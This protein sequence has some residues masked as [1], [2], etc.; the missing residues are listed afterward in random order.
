MESLKLL[1]EDFDKFL[2]QEQSQTDL[3]VKKFLMF[4]ANQAPT[5]QFIKELWDGDPHITELFNTALN[6][7]GRQGALSMFWFK[8]DTQKRA[9]LENWISHNYNG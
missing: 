9:E 4:G 8:L 3:G 6:E 5:M 1:K 7:G 2:A